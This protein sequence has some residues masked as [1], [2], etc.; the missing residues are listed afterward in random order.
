MSTLFDILLLLLSILIAGPC[1]VLFGECAAAALL[2]KREPAPC[3]ASKPL[4]TVV[5]IPA[6]DEEA[7][8]GTTLAG[9][10]TELGQ[11]DSILVVAD[12]CTDRTADIAQ[13]AGARVIERSDDE[14]RGK[15]FALDFGIAYLANEREALPPDVLVVLDADCEVLA[16]SLRQLSEY[17]WTR[18][19]PVQADDV[20]AVPPNVTP[21]IAISV[22]AFLVRNRVRPTGLQRLGL[23]CHLM[24]TGMAIPWH[25]VRALPALGPNLAEDMLMGVELA[26]Q[27]FAPMYCPAAGVRS[28]PPTRTKAAR[29]QRKR[30]EHGHLSILLDWAPRLLAR[31]I[32]TRNL[33]LLA[34]GLDLIVPPLSLLTMLSVAGTTATL[35]WWRVGG[36]PLPLL[37]MGGATLLV[38]IAFALS[39]LKFG[40]GFLPARHLAA[41]PFYV[42]WKIPLYLSFLARRRHHAWE[43]AERT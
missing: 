42:L 1:L 19:R 10:V 24:G 11:W 23:P 20:L 5:L 16:G 40:R 21:L 17:A 6:H 7:V 33:N 2:P 43:R 36:S 3:R 37:V 27:G 18:G 12:N 41:V 32:R 31:A 26:S 9:I 4:R 35:L 14:H 13:R 30:W 34:M 25:L 29:G 28:R 8:L 22:L 39:W 15:G 38:P